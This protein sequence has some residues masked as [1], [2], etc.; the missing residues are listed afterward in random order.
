MAS[1]IL[2]VSRRAC[3]SALS[4]ISDA[5]YHAD[6]LPLRALHEGLNGRGVMACVLGYPRRKQRN[7]SL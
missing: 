1:H 6:H 2:E 5:F 3:L 4:A 7:A